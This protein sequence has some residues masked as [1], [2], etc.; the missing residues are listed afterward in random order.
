MVIDH[1]PK[2]RGGG[3]HASP[4]FPGL[5]TGVLRLVTVHHHQQRLTA[6]FQDNPGKPVPEVFIVDF[7]G[8]KDD[9]GGSDN[10]SYNT[11]KA[12][13]KSSPP[14]NQHPSFYTPETLLSPLAS[15]RINI[16]CVN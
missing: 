3:A 6:I 13:V 9:G 8:A 15:V 14:T 5:K 2:P 7:T 10:W 12:P 1:H 4:N 11:R 16:T